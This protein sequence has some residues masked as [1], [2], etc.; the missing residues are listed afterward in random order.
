MR[1]VQ[2]LLIFQTRLLLSTLY[3]HFTRTSQGVIVCR[4]TATSQQVLKVNKNY[5][6]IN[7][8]MQYHKACLLEGLL[9]L[10]RSFSNTIICFLYTIIKKE[11]KENQANNFSER[12]NC[13]KLLLTVLENNSLILLCVQ[14]I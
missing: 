5:S 14:Q 12:K 9:R 3:S 6:F 7:E 1:E 2:V 10:T 4:L 8:I 11:K 13:K